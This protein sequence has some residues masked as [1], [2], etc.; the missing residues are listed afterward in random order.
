MDMGFNNFKIE[1]RTLMAPNVVES[2]IYYMVKPEFRDIVRLELLT[3]RSK[4]PI[5]AIKPKRYF[6]DYDGKEIPQKPGN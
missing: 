6:V 2:Y 4:K 1:G 5:S 3:Y